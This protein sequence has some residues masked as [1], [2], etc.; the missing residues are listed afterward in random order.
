MTFWKATIHPHK[1]A[2]SQLPH[3]LIALKT[4]CPNQ[5]KV[6]LAPFVLLPIETTIKLPFTPCEVL[7][8]VLMKFELSF[9]FW[10]YFSNNSIQWPIIEILDCVRDSFQF[11]S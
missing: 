9:L 4:P 5:K 3:E 1:Y 7:I 11:L 2:K 10:T 6:V 8:P